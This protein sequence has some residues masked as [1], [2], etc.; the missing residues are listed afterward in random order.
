[1]ASEVNPYFDGMG[2][3]SALLSAP[4]PGVASGFMLHALGQ[5]GKAFT[6]AALGANE[7]VG[8]VSLPAINQGVVGTVTVTN[9]L[10]TVNT[11]IWLAIANGNADATAAL[12]V[13]AWVAN[14]AVGTNQFSI[15]YM[16]LGA[17]MAA[18]WWANYLLIGKM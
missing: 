4:H 14:R 6:P 10:Y 11:G 12:A 16:P 7:M 15:G 18:A 3:A 1:M 9:T 5:E 8:A 13:I 17:N 2:W